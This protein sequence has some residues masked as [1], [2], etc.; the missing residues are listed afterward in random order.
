MLLGVGMGHRNLPQL[1]SDRA[2]LRA[3]CCSSVQQPLSSVSLLQEDKSSNSSW[4]QRARITP[5]Q[6]HKHKSDLFQLPP[7]IV[8]ARARACSPL[9]QVPLTHHRQHWITFFFK[10]YI[11]IY[12]WSVLTYLCTGQSL[13]PVGVTGPEG[14]DRREDLNPSRQCSSR[15]FESSENEKFIKK[16]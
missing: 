12:H 7:M 8:F 15:C 3:C 9:L 16:G 4:R 13:F 11:C 5:Q 2:G 14:L 6:V 10:F 1:P